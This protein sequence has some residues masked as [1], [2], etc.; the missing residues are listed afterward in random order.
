MMRE[1]CRRPDDFDDNGLLK[2]PVLFWVGLVVQA[3]A[4]WL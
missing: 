1:P 2:A 4:W 3:R